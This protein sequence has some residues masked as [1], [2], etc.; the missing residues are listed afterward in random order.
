MKNLKFTLT[1]LFFN[2][3][4]NLNAQETVVDK[5]PFDIPLN[6]LDNYL[7]LKESNVEGIKPGNQAKVIWAKDF[8]QQKS[9]VSFVYLHGFGASHREGEPIMSMLSEKYNANVYMARLEEHGIDRPNSF[10]YLTTENYIASALEALQIGR[11]LGEKVILVS[12]STGGTLS[13]ILASQKQEDVL[14]L[15]LFSPFID[16]INPAMAGIILPGGKEN[17]VK[18]IGGEIQKQQRPDE[19]AKYWSTAYHV[20]GYVS[21]IKMVKENMSIDTFS[22]ITIPVFLGYYY[23]NEAEQDKVVS[24]PAMLNMFEELGTS[25]ENKVKVAFPEVGNH[26]IACDLRSKDWQ[27]VYEET[28]R[29]IDTKILK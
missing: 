18:A 17:F 20:N 27:G 22:K 28:T 8:H 3:F 10:E 23:K 14:G 15:I 26:V 2:T 13:L 29:F 4:L 6:D 1:F 5:I 21:L 16:L 25:D 24:V 12:T 11:T 19:E 9:P 7:S